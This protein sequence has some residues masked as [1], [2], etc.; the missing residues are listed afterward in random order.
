VLE[1][2]IYDEGLSELCYEA[3]SLLVMVKLDEIGRNWDRF[4]GL[5]Q[6]S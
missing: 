4:A 5:L 6:A 2:S 3:L 1:R